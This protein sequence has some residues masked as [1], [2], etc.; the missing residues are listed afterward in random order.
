MKCIFCKQS[1]TDVINSR[2]GKGEHEV[3]RRRKCLSCKEV[4]TTSENFA[5]DSLFVVKRNMTRKRFVY[6]KLFTSILDAVS[7]G[8][9]HDRGDDAVLAKKIIKQVVADLFKHASKYLSSQDIIRSVY[10][11]LEKE[12]AFFALKY[13]SYS[14]YRLATVQG[15]KGKE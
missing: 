7:G 1:E 2:K 8:K 12:D 3:W 9:G 14:A 13:A 6:E 4:F 11:L 10:G 5:Y 15:K